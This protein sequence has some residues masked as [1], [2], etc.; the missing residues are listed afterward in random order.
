MLAMLIKKA[1]CYIVDFDIAHRFAYSSTVVKNFFA[2][3]M[4]FM[5]IQGGYTL[6]A[7]LHQSNLLLPLSIPS[8][9]QGSVAEDSLIEGILLQLFDGPLSI[10][11]YNTPAKQAATTLYLP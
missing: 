6:V 4:V 7:C 9:P 8:P 3:H 5:S 1:P 10:S 11:G 2:N